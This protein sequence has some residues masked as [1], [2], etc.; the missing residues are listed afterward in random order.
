M[1]F[2]TRSKSR[3]LDDLVEKLRP[4]PRTHPDR[5]RLIRMII[6]L[7]HE[8]GRRVNDDDARLFAADD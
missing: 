4:L 2:R 7:S 8:I 5:P 1:E 3:V 6:D